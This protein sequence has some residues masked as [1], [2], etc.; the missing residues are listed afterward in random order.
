MKRCTYRLMRNLKICSMCGKKILLLDYSQNNKLTPIMKQKQIC[1]DCAYWTDIL[2]SPPE[3]FE[4]IGN[5]C[6]QIHP[7]Y[8]NPKDKTI[9]LGGGGEMHYYIRPD[10]TLFSSND[11]WYI[12]KIPDHLAN[13]FEPTAIEI[14]NRLY[15]LLIRNNKMC[16]S[17]S[18]F[19]RYR[20]LRFNTS[21]EEADGPFNVIPKKWKIGDEHCGYFIDR[22]NLTEEENKVKLKK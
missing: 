2:K 21:L 14:S 12:G 18:C 15:R 20:C 13:Q 3:R 8:S 7:V 10:S 16:R 17:R 19:D 1:F 22:N 5:K 6:Y 4:V 9:I 11:V